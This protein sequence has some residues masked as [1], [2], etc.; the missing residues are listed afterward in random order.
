MPLSANRVQKT[1]HRI[2]SV[3]SGIRLQQGPCPGIALLFPVFSAGCAAIENTYREKVLALMRE[4]AGLYGIMNVR[5]CMK[6]L[7][8]LLSRQIGT[9]KR[10][11]DFRG[12]T[13]LKKPQ[14][15]L[16]TSGVISSW[17]SYTSFSCSIYTF[18]ETKES[19]TCFHSPSLPDYLSRK[20]SYPLRD[21]R[22]CYP[23]TSAAVLH[24][25]LIH[26]SPSLR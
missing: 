3:I 19:Y 24:Q 9:E 23:L 1:V 20:I 16:Y 22:N 17:L 18:S 12:E 5:H 21:L 10:S 26:G 4:M 8:T 15:L 2:I 14:I 25:R 13:S 7:E 11:M 6:I